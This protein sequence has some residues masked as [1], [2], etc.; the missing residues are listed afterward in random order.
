MSGQADRSGHRSRQQA[1]R[2]QRRAEGYRE[3]VVWLHEDVRH[4]IDQN[5][6]AGRF[7]S[8]SEALGTAIEEFFVRKES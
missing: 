3:T 1:H 4:V 2:E 8:Q 7:K 6:E 5:I